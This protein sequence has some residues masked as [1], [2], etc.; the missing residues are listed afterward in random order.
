MNFVSN[1]P[2]RTASRS[3]VFAGAV[4]ASLMLAASPA[5]AA[6][7][8]IAVDDDMQT[9]GGDAGYGVGTGDS[10]GAAEADALK[11]CKS[12]GNGACKIAVSYKDMCGAYASTRKYA[13]H[14]TGPTKAAASSAAIS[15]CG[16]GACKIV[17]AECVGDN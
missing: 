3:F 2:R 7:D 11:N 17:I 8:S 13:G 6:W 1:R 10:R 15:A 5:L 9:H 16:D 12:E 14:G 4:L